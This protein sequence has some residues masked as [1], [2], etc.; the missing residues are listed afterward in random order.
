M[1]PVGTFPLAYTT[2]YKCITDGVVTQLFNMANVRFTRNVSYLLVWSF[3]RPWR[4]PN[5]DALLDCLDEI[6]L[7]GLDGK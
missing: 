7:D 6:A 1:G 4:S 5:M 3:S 2:Y